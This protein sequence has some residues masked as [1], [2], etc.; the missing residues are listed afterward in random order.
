MEYDLD[1]NKEFN[2]VSGRISK[3][4]RYY[5]DYG[6]LFEGDSESTTVTGENADA[7]LDAINE[8]TF[9]RID[10]VQKLSTGVSMKRALKNVVAVAKALSKTGK[11]KGVVIHKTDKSFMNATGEALGRGM[12]VGKGRIHIYAPAAMENTSFHEAFHDLI[13]EAVGEEAVQELS[14]ALYNGLSGNLRKKYNNFL[15]GQQGVHVVKERR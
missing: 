5:N 14:V 15:A 8:V 4:D 2:R 13:L 1:I 11:F 9:N 10:Q 7:V 6:S 12:W 3:I